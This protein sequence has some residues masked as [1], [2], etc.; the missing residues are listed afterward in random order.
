VLEDGSKAGFRKAVL[1][2]LY[3]LHDGQSPKEEDCT[4]I[5]ACLLALLHFGRRNAA[6]YIFEVFKYAW[7][8]D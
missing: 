5:C 6:Q 1:F 8:C 4:Y 3:L 7:W 2:V